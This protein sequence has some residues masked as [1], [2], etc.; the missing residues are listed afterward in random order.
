VPDRCNSHSAS[1]MRRSERQ[2]NDNPRTAIFAI[3]RGCGAPMCARYSIHKCQAKS[4]PIGI[5]ALRPALKHVVQHF[6]I[7]SRSIIFHN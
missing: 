7:E 2:R 3:R 1:A 4:V 5:S 6:R